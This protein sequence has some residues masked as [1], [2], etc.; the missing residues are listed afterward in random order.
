MYIKNKVGG[1]KV[2][3]NNVFYLS[4]IQEQTNNEHI[5]IKRLEM[6]SY[7]SFV[8]NFAKNPNHKNKIKSLNQ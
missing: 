3:G 7:N 6:H 2:G 5:Y 8:L 1:N 4:K